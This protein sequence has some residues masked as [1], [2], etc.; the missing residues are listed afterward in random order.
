MNSSEL[1]RLATLER[2][3]DGTE[4]LRVSLDEFVD[5]RGAVH[6]YVSARL[7]FKKA[8]GEWCPTKKGVTIRR[9]E[10]R[11]FGVA[12]RT[13]LTAMNDGKPLENKPKVS[14]P[15]KTG[16]LLEPLEADPEGM[17]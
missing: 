2:G 7:W 9:S 12:L 6:H 4:Q 14:A 8:D 15:Q 3:K 5:D 10:I 11:E 17:F 16:T 13:A 1:Q